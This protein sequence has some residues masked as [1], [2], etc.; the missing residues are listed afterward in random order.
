MKLTVLSIDDYSSADGE[1][2]PNPR[3]GFE[4]EVIQELKMTPS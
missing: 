2:A 1:M 3:P 4:T